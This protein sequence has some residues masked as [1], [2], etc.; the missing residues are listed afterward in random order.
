VSA[1]EGFYLGDG[2]YARTDG[3]GSVVLTTGAHEGIHVTNTI[4]LEPEVF[5]AL[6]AFVER[7]R[8]DREVP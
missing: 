2:V 8:V 1:L 4:V 3:Y 6:M 5:E 7:A